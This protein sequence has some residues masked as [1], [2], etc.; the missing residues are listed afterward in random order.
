MLAHFTILQKRKDNKLIVEKFII[1]KNNMENM[2]NALKEKIEKSQ[3]FF[4]S[5]IESLS[6][7]KATP[8]LVEDLLVDYFG[9]PTPINQVATI[10][11][12]DARNILI[13]PWDKKQLKEIEK[14]INLSQLGF[15]PVN[16]GETIRIT[17]PQ[18]TE[19]RRKE[20]VKHLHELLEEAKVTIRGAREDAMK[21]VKNLEKNGEIGE[22]ERFTRQD[23]IQKIVNSG[24]EKLEENSER[25][26]KEIMTI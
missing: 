16:N 17:V 3:S 7:G 23:E 15:N 11:I 2:I 18:P 14:A 24:N 25:K 6:V 13:Q 9:T 12:P 26:E 10:N 1:N 22:D 5:E 21:E 8:S 4:K 19:E 20:I